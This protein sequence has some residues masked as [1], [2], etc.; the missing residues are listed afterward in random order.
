MKAVFHKTTR[1]CLGLISYCPDGKEGDLVGYPQSEIVVKEI[2]KEILD[3]L[4]DNSNPYNYQNLYLRRGKVVI[5]ENK[6]KHLLQIRDEN[7]KLIMNALD[8]TKPLEERFDNL[9]ALV[10]K[11]Y[12][13]R[14]K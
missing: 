2:G 6:N 9:L 1:A 11:Q 8:D 12:V 5:D 4:D 14:K 13:R 3:I 7:D 10:I